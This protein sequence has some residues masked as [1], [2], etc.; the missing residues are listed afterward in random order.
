MFTFR[1]ITEENIG[2]SA[3]DAAIKALYYELGEGT[4]PFI[5][6]ISMKFNPHNKLTTVSINFQLLF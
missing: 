1:F 2:P 3:A 5:S 4:G 6:R